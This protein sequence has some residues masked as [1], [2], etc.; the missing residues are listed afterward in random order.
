MAW[1]RL[2]LSPEDQEPTW[3]AECQKYTYSTAYLIPRTDSPE[4]R[5]EE[6]DVCK[7]EKHLPLMQSQVFNSK[8]NKVE[9]RK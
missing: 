4:E 9:E 7:D 1:K 8:T 2:D 6:C 5:W 3:C